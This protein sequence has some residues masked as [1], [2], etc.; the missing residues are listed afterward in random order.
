MIY[1]QA[2]S[3]LFHKARHQQF[4][5]LQVPPFDHADAENSQ[6]H[7]I[8]LDFTL[9]E[10]PIAFWSGYFHTTGHFSYENKKSPDFS[11]LFVVR[12]QL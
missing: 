6:Q 5:F 1:N 8:R 11:K 9:N 3:K 4:I 7:F 2:F 10:I 12:S